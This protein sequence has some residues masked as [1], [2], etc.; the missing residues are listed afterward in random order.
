MATPGDFSSRNMHTRTKKRPT[1]NDIKSVNKV[2]S[3]VMV[4]HNR[5]QQPKAKIPLVSYGWKKKGNA[6][7]VT[8]KIENDMQKV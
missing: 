8:A 5:S 2:I 6:H 3:E 1:K 4:S 7:N